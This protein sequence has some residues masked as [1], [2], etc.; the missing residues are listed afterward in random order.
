MKPNI[1]AVYVT[2][3][4]LPVKIKKNVLNAKKISLKMTTENASNVTTHAIIVPVK[5][6]VTALNVKKAFIYMENSAE[7]ANQTVKLVQT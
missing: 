3:I 2:Q 7:N 6:I 5:Q 4:A 1:I